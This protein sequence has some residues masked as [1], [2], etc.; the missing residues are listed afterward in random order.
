MDEL[1]EIDKEL[2]EI[3]AIIKLTHDDYEKVEDD[4]IAVNLV[5]EEPKEV[6]EEKKEEKKEGE[7]EG[8]EPP[9]PPPADEEDKQD[10]PKFKPEDFA[11]TNTE[12]KPRTIG[13]FFSGWKNSITKNNLFNEHQSEGYETEL[14][15]DSLIASVI[16][17]QLS[18]NKIYIQ[19]RFA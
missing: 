15:L 7:G 13:Q 9:P 6:K 17:G 2:G 5:V 18:K 16:G 14:V 4:R 3:Q 1:F 11:W 10:K 19:V 12:G 8:E